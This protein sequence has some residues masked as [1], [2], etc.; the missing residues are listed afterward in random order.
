[1]SKAKI[2]IKLPNK[3][4]DLMEVALKDLRRVERSKKYV[5]DMGKWHS[6]NSVCHVCY[7]GAVMTRVLKPDEGIGAL[8]GTFGNRTTHK[9]LALNAIRTGDISDALDILNIKYV[10]KY[11]A[12][13]TSNIVVKKHV[14]PIKV[15][16][17]DYDVDKT[18]WHKDMRKI[19]RIL[20]KASL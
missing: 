3:L 7:G 11:N 17:C 12:G 6:P 16:E 5:V 4:S 13:F 20:R 1:M 10:W 2:S 9:F 15:P 14:L 8:R 19:I 18:Q